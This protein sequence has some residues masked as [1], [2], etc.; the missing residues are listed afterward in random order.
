MAAARAVRGWQQ[1]GQR[2]RGQYERR[3]DGEGGS[4][5]GGVR[6]AI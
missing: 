3:C 5:K 6:V 4:S 2:E 1:L